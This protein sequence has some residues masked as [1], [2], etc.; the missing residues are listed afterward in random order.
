MCK[1]R[2]PFCLPPQD[3]GE[4]LSYRVR[5]E[6]AAKG[7]EAGLAKGCPLL[8]PMVSV[9]QAEP[10]DTEQKGPGSSVFRGSNS[11]AERAGR[12]EVPPDRA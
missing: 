6:A 5:E 9:S 12:Q 4:C 3:E 11:E 2:F 10:G 8:A 7:G 1:L